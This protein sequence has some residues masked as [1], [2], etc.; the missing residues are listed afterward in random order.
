M[1]SP[2]VPAP[3]DASAPF[4]EGAKRG[5]LVLQHCR[6][7]DRWHYPV[8]QRCSYCRGHDLVWEV[9][10]GRGVIYSHGVLHRANHPELQA[11]LPV[12]LAVVDLECGVRMR[13]N[14]IDAEPSAVRAGAPVEV[15]FLPLAEG[16]AVPVFRPA[17][18]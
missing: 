5:E 7:C 10:S 13:T 9:T 17:A 4:F 12:V 3:D 15:A 18:A 8:R 6:D 14:L 1:S 2:L 16:H 11:R